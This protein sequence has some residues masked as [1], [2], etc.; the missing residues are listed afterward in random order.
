M[1]PT[2]SKNSTNFNR[3]ICFN[4]EVMVPNVAL[5]N[6]SLIKI[7][8]TQPFNKHV[9]YGLSFVKLRIAAGSSM[10]REKAN[11]SLKV[12]V[13]SPP[14]L[15]LKFR[16][17]SPDSE[18]DSPSSSGLFKRWKNSNRTTND[19]AVSVK[20]KEIIPA[21]SIKEAADNI[22]KNKKQL[23]DVNDNK[24]LKNAELFK[25][26]EKLIGMNTV[27]DTE[28]VDNCSTKQ[29]VIK[30]SPLIKSKSKKEADIERKTLFQ[31]KSKKYKPFNQLLNGVVLVISGIQNPDRTDLRNK[32]IELGAKYKA[33]WDQTCTHLM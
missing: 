11:E 2:E 20:P 22:L 7:T 9:Q 15:P 16:E 1:T 13:C 26:E 25:I 8:C 12:P 19:S 5:E 4:S 29:Q 10:N 27:E 33:N 30:T 23:L 14:K 32:A 21:L 3:V 24:V 31:G 17:V 18:N 6:W 28:K